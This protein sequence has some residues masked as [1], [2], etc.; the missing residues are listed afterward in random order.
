MVDLPVYDSRLPGAVLALS[1][2]WN[3]CQP[4]HATYTIRCYCCALSLFWFFG[5]LFS[6]NADRHNAWTTFELLHVTP[7]YS[8][9]S[10]NSASQC[11]VWSASCAP[12][13][14]RVCFAFIRDA[15]TWLPLHRTLFT[16]TGL[17]LLAICAMPHLFV[18]SDHHV[19][20]TVPKRLAACSRRRAHS[21]LFWVT[22][23]RDP[24]GGYGGLFLPLSI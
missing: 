13:F 18:T 3:T 15:L 4:G 23:R 5:A 11:S 17:I 9:S 12:A 6:R 14:A 8:I 24:S 2:L 19:R 21:G 16:A 22:L 20:T 1:F 10:R 7:V